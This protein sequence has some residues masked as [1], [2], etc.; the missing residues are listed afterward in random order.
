MKNGCRG[1]WTL[2]AGL[3]VLVLALGACSA[4]RLAYNQADRLLAWKIDDYVDL[5]REQQALFRQIFDGIWRWHRQTQLPAYAGELEAL[6]QKADGDGLGRADFDA[7]LAQVERYA[8]AINEQLQ[9]LYV[10]IL[11]TLSEAQLTQIERRLADELAARVEAREDSEKAAPGKRLQSRI[12][13]WIG[14]TTPAQQELIADWAGAGQATDPQWWIEWQR[15]WNRDFLAL[16]QTRA[17]PGFAERSA[18][19]DAVH[20]VAHDPRLGPAVAED[21]AR[22][23]DLLVELS[24][25]LEPRQRQRFSGRLRDYADDFRALS[26]R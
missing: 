25:T 26:S 1:G 24:G 3:V 19:F 21:R 13:D 20:Q 17:E 22:F 6:A 12:E 9:P 18:R 7:L 2:R 5:D 23:V 10:Q 11:P 14:R 16:L 15:Q 4:V 8:D